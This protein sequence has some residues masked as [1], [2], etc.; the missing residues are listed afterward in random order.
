MIPVGVKLYW[1]SLAEERRLCEFA[2]TQ[3]AAAMSTL[4]MEIHT[5]IIGDKLYASRNH[6]QLRQVYQGSAANRSQID[7][8]LTLRQVRRP[9]EI[10][11]A[12]SAPNLHTSE[13]LESRT[14]REPLAP[15][16]PDGPYHGESQS[17][18]KYQNFA[19]SAH[20]CNGLVRHSSGPAP[21][22]EWQL[23][24][25]GGIHQNDFKTKWRR[26]HAR[27]HQSFDYMAADRRYDRRYGAL[28]IETIRDDPVSFRRWP[29]CEGTQAFKQD[30]LGEAI[31]DL[32]PLMAQ[33]AA[34]TEAPSAPS[35]GQSGMAR[36]VGGKKKEALQQIAA[37]V[38]PQGRHGPRRVLAA[39]IWLGL[40]PEDLDG[41]KDQN[42][43][44]SAK[45]PD[46]ERARRIKE[47]RVGVWE[48]LK[49]ARLIEL[50]KRLQFMS[51][52]DVRR[53]LRVKLGGFAAVTAFAWLFGCNTNHPRAFATA[54]GHMQV[55]RFQKI[56][57]V[58]LQV[59]LFAQLSAD[60]IEARK[61]ENAKAQDKRQQ[62]IQNTAKKRAQ[63]EDETYNNLVNRISQARA[64][65]AKSYSKEGMSNAI[66]IGIQRR[67]RCFDQALERENALLESIETANRTAEERLQV[68]RQEIEDECRRKAEE[69]Q[70]KFQERQIKIYAQTQD[71][72]L[73]L[74][75]WCYQSF[76]RSKDWVEKKLEDHAQFKAH[77]K[78]RC[79]A[80]QD[81]M[82]ARSKSA[83][84][85]TKK[86]HEKWRANY[87]KVVA[88]QSQNNSNLL[89]RQE[90]ARVRAEETMALKLKCANDVHSFKEV[91]YKTWGELQRRRMEEIQK[92]RD[93]QSQALV[94]KIAEGQAKA[95]AREEGAMEVKN[96]RQRLGAD[97]LALNDRA[98]EGFIKIKC[99]PDERRIIKV[100]S[101]LG[102]EMPK[103]PDE[104]EDEDGEK[105][106]MPKAQLD[107]PR[108]K[109]FHLASYWRHLI[110][111]TSRGKKVRR[112][113]RYEVTLREDP[114]DTNGAKIHD[115]RN[116]GC[117]VEMLGKKKWVGH[118]HYDPL[119]QRWPHGDA[120]L[121]H[122]RSLQN[123]MKTIASCARRS[124]PERTLTFLRVGSHSA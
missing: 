43:E 64:A 8:N 93:A 91:K 2:R 52:Q 21:S 58:N 54:I 110:E 56:K 46:A 83:G 113:I 84:E 9:K 38:D 66:E 33:T 95:R 44:V 34:A 68:R 6:N 24:L 31:S 88:A 48:G 105:K 57:D 59:Q 78:S 53:C 70:A 122:L 5:D 28:S 32:S 112:A 111:D 25:R 19:N 90:A 55:A 23:N 7:W 107:T 104:D 45:V 86:A 1:C 89:A 85:I 17:R 81:F 102:F 77:Y 92:S 42:V 87:N 75:A 74:F 82:K 51:E 12:S 114:E 71:A 35:K 40:E 97:T 101:D 124:K 14:R 39:M 49:K 62:G 60:A 106:A 11:S 96:R 98:K 121:Y 16:H 50:E 119:V 116:E 4:P 61:K 20:M 115:T 30:L 99:E 117:L 10:K 79:Q 15:E 94:I 73:I 80:G 103:L 29:G 72:L 3:L 22:I 108:P 41:S 76:G 69:S 67:Q 100:M 109:V 65:R 118:Q 123:Q 63:W 37:L 27:P 26:H 18:G 36:P 13:L 120:K 47:E